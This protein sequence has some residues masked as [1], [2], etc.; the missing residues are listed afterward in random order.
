MGN[1][2]ETRRIVLAVTGALVVFAA[3]PVALSHLTSA[4]SQQGIEIGVQY[5]QTVQSIY[6]ESGAFDQAAT[7]SGQIADA[8]GDETFRLSAE[9]L[10]RMYESRPSLSSPPAAEDV[11]PA[12]QG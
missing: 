8:L 11:A 5:Y 6:L 9:E 7:F 12:E 1:D 3:E 2:N 4:T 10:R